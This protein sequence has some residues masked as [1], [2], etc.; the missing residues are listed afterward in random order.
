MRTVPTPYYLTRAVTMVRGFKLGIGL[1]SGVLLFS[2]WALAETGGIKFNYSQIFIGNLPIGTTVSMKKVANL[3]IRVTNKFDK[4]MQITIAIE[5]PTKEILAGYEAIPEAKWIRTEY[6]SVTVAAFATLDSDLLVTLP[7][8]TK[9][10]GKKYQVNVSASVNH[11]GGGGFQVGYAA[12]GVFLFSVAPVKN[13][14]A[15]KQVENK[16]LDVKFEIKPGRVDLWKIAPG[17]RVS[18]VSEANLPVEVTNTSDQAQTYRI[19]SIT[20]KETSMLLD[21]DTHFGG[22]ADHVTLKKD[23]I[24]LSPGKHEQVEMTIQVPEQADFSQGPIGYLVQ[25]SSGLD[26]GAIQ[27]ITVYLHKEARPE[28]FVLP[29][30]K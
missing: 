17:Q 9:I 23:E 26:S 15:L 13:N 12:K 6:A 8:D 4:P 19:M 27:Y 18:V 5:K 24:R 10:L 29:A 20:P 2:S 22:S 25:I 16:P 1:I 28:K 7:N 30:K 21:N 3:P 14:A 11:I